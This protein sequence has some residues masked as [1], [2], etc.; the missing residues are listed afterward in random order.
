MLFFDTIVITKIILFFDTIV[1]TG[2]IK[3]SSHCTVYLL[4]HFLW[5]NLG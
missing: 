5:H 4:Y 1:I 2:D 3:L